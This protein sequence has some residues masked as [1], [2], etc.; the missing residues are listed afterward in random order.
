M[1][2]SLIYETAAAPSESMSFFLEFATPP[3]ACIWNMFNIVSGKAYCFSISSMFDC[4]T[5]LVSGWEGE[6]IWP[7]RISFLSSSVA[8]SSHRERV[9]YTIV[10][11]LQ[12]FQR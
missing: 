3:S 8:V 2:K 5:S 4:Y 7:D 11:K 1:P 9:K 12:L 10:S 6:P